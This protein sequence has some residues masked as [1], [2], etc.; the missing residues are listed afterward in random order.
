[1]ILY[2]VQYSYAYDFDEPQGASMQF[3]ETSLNVAATD[4]EHA[5]R[6][7]R[8]REVG[9][10]LEGDSDEDIEDQRITEITVF[11]VTRIAD[12]DVAEAFDVTTDD[13]E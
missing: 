9:R 6:L 12:I 13:D 2:K 11:E 5:I 10:V 3:A 1:M 4:A 8:E 7:V